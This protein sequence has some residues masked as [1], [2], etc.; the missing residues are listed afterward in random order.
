MHVSR[1]RTAD[2]EVVTFGCRLNAYE[3][4]AVHDLATSAGITDTVIVNTCAVTTEAERQARQA[5]RKLRR[6]RPHAKIVATGCAVQINPETWAMMPEVDRVV[7]N[8]EKM[9]FET[10]HRE[11]PRVV[12]SDIMAV[13][14]AAVHMIDGFPAKARAFVE[15]QQ[16]CDHRCTFCIIPFGRGNNRSVPIGDIVTQIRRLIDRGIIEVVLTGLISQV[17]EMIIPGQPSL[18]Q[19][20]RRLLMQIPELKRL[21]LSSI[22]V[23]EAADKALRDLIANEPRLMPHLHLFTSRRRYYS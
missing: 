15:I 3:S 9:Q 4:Q 20:M 11:A 21:R 22:D 12:V 5:I 7:G 19:M 13:R 17:M 10:W 6:V 18:G 16:G 2:V 1:E 8:S 14:E 23:A